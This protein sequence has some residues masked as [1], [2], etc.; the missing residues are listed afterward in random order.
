MNNQT[1]K[2]KINWFRTI[3]PIAL[4]LVLVTLL[5]YA[6]YSW[7][8]RD[9]TP[10]VHQE[11]IKIVAGS[12]LVFLFN[13]NAM[14]ESSSITD[15]VDGFEDF[16]FKSVSNSTGKSDHFYTL[17]Y[18]PRG[19]YFDEYKQIKVSEIED[20]EIN[21][22]YKDPEQTQDDVYDTRMNYTLLGKKHGYIELTFAVK[23]LEGTQTKVKLA[24]S[25]YIK[26]AA[27]AKDSE[28]AEKAVAAMR[29]SITVPD[30]TSS[31][32]TK[33]ILFVPT[34]DGTPNGLVHSHEGVSTNTK[35]E[36]PVYL[37]KEYDDDKYQEDGGVPKL[38]KAVDENLVL[39]ASD[40]CRNF[41]NADSNYDLFT[42]N[43]EGNPEQIIVRIWLEGEDVDCIDDKVLG[44]ELD[45][46]IKFAA[47]DLSNS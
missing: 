42:L 38:R 19:K 37:T 39:N 41:P 35:D 4:L 22:E 44:G 5:T 20:A 14:T 16:V 24:P 45:I 17:K 25:S 3:R 12:S 15:L 43:S 1:E 23:A 8:K 30:A 18:S 21:D 10:E 7:M 11:N 28:K 32:G 31:D 26:A 2:K 9:W 13:E 47:E 34:V 40:D 46:L 6:T 27:N 33:T 29:F 36:T